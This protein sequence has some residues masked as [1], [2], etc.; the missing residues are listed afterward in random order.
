MDQ[1]LDA[2]F[3]DVSDVGCC[4]AGL[5]TG[6]DRMWINEPESIDDNLSFDRLNGVDH[7]RDRTGGEGFE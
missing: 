6:E 5:L 2:G 7:D 4:L 3:V 1:G